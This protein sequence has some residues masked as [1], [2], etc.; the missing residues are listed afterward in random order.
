M[1]DLIL[2][3]PILIW[4][5]SVALLVTM[6]IALASGAAILINR[7]RT[8]TARPRA[9]KVVLGAVILGLLFCGGALALRVGP[10]APLV[11]TV[12]RFAE[13]QAA[14]VPN[15]AM[16]RVRDGSFLSL[17]SLRGRVV[18]LNVWA[19]WCP[20][21]RFEMP[22]LVRLESAHPDGQVVVVTVSDESAEQQLKFAAGHALPKNACTGSLG[23]NTG[24]FRPF[25]LILDRTGKLRAFYFGA[26]DYAFFE[27]N[28]RD[29]L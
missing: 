14:S 21:C 23:W 15:L 9:G 27:R 1:L 22:D 19:T 17:G 5:W 24:T 20:P 12:G 2:S 4:K 3:H 16:T 6:I 25:S 29:L 18:V 8:R 28:V 26:H 7:M 10:L 13:W 11:E